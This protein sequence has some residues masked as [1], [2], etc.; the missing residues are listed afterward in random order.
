MPFF[1]RREESSKVWA[2]V[3]PVGRGASLA[4]ASVIL[5]L[6]AGPS[7]SGRRRPQWPFY[8]PSEQMTRFVDLGCGWP[9]SYCPAQAGHQRPGRAI[10]RSLPESSFPSLTLGSGPSGFPRELSGRRPKL[11][12]QPRRSAS[13]ALGA[14]SWPVGLPETIFQATAEASATAMATPRRRSR[15]L[16]YFGAGVWPVGLPETFWQVSERRNIWTPPR[17]TWFQVYVATWAA[18]TVRSLGNRARRRA[19][20]WPFYQ[21]W[22]R[23]QWPQWTFMARSVDFGCRW[24]ISHCP[25]QAIYQ[26]PGRGRNPARARRVPFFATRRIIEGL[27]LGLARRAARKL[28]PVVLTLGS[29]PS[30]FPR[31]LSRRRPKLPR[32]PWQ[33]RAVVCARSVIAALGAGP[34]GFPKQLRGDGRSFRDSHGKPAPS[35]ARAPFFWGWGLARRASRNNLPGDGQS[36]CDSVPRVRFRRFSA[37]EWPDGLPETSS[38]RCKLPRRA[39]RYCGAGIE[40]LGWGLARRAARKLVPV[41]LTLGSGSSGFPRKLSRRRLKLPRQP[42]RGASLALASVILALGAGPL[43]FPKQ[44]SGRRPKLPRQPWQTRAALRYSG[45][46]GW[47]VGLPETIFRVQSF[48]DSL[49][50]ARFRRFGAGGWPDGLPETSFRAM[51]SGGTVA[52]RAV[53]STRSGQMAR[54]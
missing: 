33:T 29:G 35:F 51:R 39:L 16:R 38:E 11:L 8:Q 22:L 9:I 31:K 13:L 36:I 53:L 41:V 26:R 21:Q 7:F 30:G 3:W 47:P 18:Q 6:G 12:R 10:F 4:L 52:A 15:A 2:W 37:G 28:V 54:S 45:A 46:G 43:G 19:S 44:F 17:E 42:G 14:G 25:V 40:G 5:A 48:C 49:P 24:P 1:S 23:S 20:L 50:R 27:G 34:S 32:Q